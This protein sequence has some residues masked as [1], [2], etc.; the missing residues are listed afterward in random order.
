MGNL[1]DTVYQTVLKIGM[2]K[3]EPPIFYHAPNG[4]RFEIGGSEPIYLDIS[5]G[6]GYPTIFVLGK[7]T[8]VEN[9]AN[10]DL[11]SKPHWAVR[12]QVLFYAWIRACL[13]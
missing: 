10:W 1:P 4:I 13:W 5:M 3:L 8:F 9:L 12:S 7:F 2:D 6:K 11:Q